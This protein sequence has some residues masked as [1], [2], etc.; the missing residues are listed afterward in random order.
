MKQSELVTPPKQQE[1]DERVAICTVDGG[2]S[3]REA[4]RI[5]V[6]QMPGA[7]RQECPRTW[8]QFNRQWRAVVA[9]VYGQDKMQIAHDSLKK[10]HGVGSFKG[11]T[12]GQILASIEKLE[13]KQ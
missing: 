1:F 9:D 6:E 11:L 5:A 2:M 3:K 8:K 7:T 13:A 10:K 4:F 12:L